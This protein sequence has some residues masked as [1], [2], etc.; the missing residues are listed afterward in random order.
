M[1]FDVYRNTGKAEIYP[2]VLDVQSDIIGRRQTRLAI[3]LFPH[4]NYI[5]PRV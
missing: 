2:L 3:P 4:E 5:G 1:Q